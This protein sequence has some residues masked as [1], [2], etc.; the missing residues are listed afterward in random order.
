MTTHEA[1]ENLCANTAW[2]DLP[3]SWE[4]KIARYVLSQGLSLDEFLTSP[5]VSDLAGELPDDA[6]GL[7]GVARAIYFG[8]PIFFFHPSLVGENGR[9]C[10]RCKRPFAIGEKIKRGNGCWKYHVDCGSAKV[11]EQTAKDHA[12]AANQAAPHEGRVI[13]KTGGL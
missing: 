10:P 9:R 7:K 4:A 11:A 2:I 6:R 8:T 3:E 5:G 1:Y 13:R 12:P